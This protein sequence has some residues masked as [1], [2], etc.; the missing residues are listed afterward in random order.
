MDIED[1]EKQLKILRNEKNMSFINAAERHM[2]SPT[3]YKIERGENYTLKSFFKYLSVL[4]ATLLVDDNAVSSQI[5]MGIILQAKRIALGYSLR[6]F[7]REVG[8]TPTK[9]ANIEKG[10]GCAKKNLLKYLS[11]IPVTFKLI[12]T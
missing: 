11:I 3:I 5:E 12:H 2:N 7:E 9:L 10:R 8:L 4:D 6:K 1:I